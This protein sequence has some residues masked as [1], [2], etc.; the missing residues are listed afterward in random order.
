MGNKYTNT[1]GITKIYSYSKQRNWINKL[2]YKFKMF[3]EDYD[4]LVKKQNGL[5]AI[6]NQPPK[7]RRL[8]VDHNHKT[9]KVRGLLCNRCNLAIGLFDDLVQILDQAIN[10]LNEI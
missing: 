9:R 4:A 7:S 3:P 6:C 10:Y 2:Q 5:C 8:D 1:Q